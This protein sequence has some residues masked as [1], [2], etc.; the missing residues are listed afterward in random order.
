MIQISVIFILLAVI[1]AFVRFL[2]GPTTLD[3]LVAVD[4]LTTIG[5]AGLVLYVALSRAIYMEVPLVYAL[6]AFVGVVAIVR[7]YERGM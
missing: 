4:V 6:L 3:R 7:F 5:V 1:V 2:M